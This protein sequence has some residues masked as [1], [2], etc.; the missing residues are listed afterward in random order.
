MKVNSYKLFLRIGMVCGLVP[1]F[2]E[3]KNSLVDALWAKMYPGVFFVVTLI[4]RLMYTNIN[5][6]EVLFVTSSSCIN[7]TVVVTVYTKRKY[8]KKWF[9][10]F[11]ITHTKIKSKFT[12]S[13]RLGWYT[14]LK[15]TTQY[16]LIV[17]SEILTKGF[18]VLNKNCENPHGEIVPGITFV[19]D[20]RA[21]NVSVYKGIYRNL[22]DM[23]VTLNELFSYL[24]AMSLLDLVIS[25]TNFFNYLVC[26]QKDDEL[27]MEKIAIFIIFIVFEAVSMFSLC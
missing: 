5:L 7:F 10:L 23:S 15:F 13:I 19:F 9:K 6:N 1:W 4:V 12:G 24:L 16:L 2:N 8:W 20:I 25:I 3:K 14:I 22:Y 17:F 21:I 26:L 18:E 11:R 27:N